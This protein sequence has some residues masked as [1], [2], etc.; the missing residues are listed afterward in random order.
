VNAEKIA[1]RIDAAP[2]DVARFLHEEQALGRVR[3]T[4]GGRWSLVADAFP[5][6]TL[7]ALRTLSSG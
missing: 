5:P 6:E 3:R 2:D 1:S 7:E 4:D